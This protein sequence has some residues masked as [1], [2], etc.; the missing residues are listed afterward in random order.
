MFYRYRFSVRSIGLSFPFVSNAKSL[1]ANEPDAAAGEEVVAVNSSLFLRIGE[2]GTVERE[3]LH[4]EGGK[5]FGAES[6]DRT[7]K[8]KHR[9]P[10]L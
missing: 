7:L 9:H 5:A 2:N 3:E 4:R 6:S 10:P 1:P 8:K